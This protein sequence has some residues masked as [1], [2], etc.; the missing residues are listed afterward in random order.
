MD[1]VFKTPF[2]TRAQCRDPSKMDFDS[3]FLE[4][5]DSGIE[6]LPLFIFDK[7]VNDDEDEDDELVKISL[8]VKKYVGLTLA[9]EVL[10]TSYDFDKRFM[11]HLRRLMRG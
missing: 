5:K 1:E 7:L 6:S 2:Y 4:L 11:Q 3:V 10:H 8:R 9:S